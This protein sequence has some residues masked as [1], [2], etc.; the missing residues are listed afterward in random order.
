MLVHQR[1]KL[2]MREDD[3]QTNIIMSAGYLRLATEGPVRWI[4][5]N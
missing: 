3:I 2:E 4:S 5:Y 1:V